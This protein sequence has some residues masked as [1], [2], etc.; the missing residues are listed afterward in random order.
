MLAGEQRLDLP[1]ELPDLVD[2]LVELGDLSLEEGVATVLRG[3][4]VREEYVDRAHDHQTE[5]D[6]QSGEHGEMLARA[7]PALLAMRQ[8]VDTYRHSGSNLRMASPQ[9]TIIDG[10]STISRFSWMR[11]EACIAPNGL[12]TMVG[13]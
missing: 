10:A 11:G 5:H 9:A 4:S 7:L 12:A 13:T 6:R 3:N 2:L 1:S 8:E